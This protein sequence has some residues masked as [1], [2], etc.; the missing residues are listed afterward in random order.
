MFIFVEHKVW[1]ENDTRSHQLFKRMRDIHDPYQTFQNLN[2]NVKSSFN[3]IKIN[4][5]RIKIEFSIPSSSILSLSKLWTKKQYKNKNLILLH[6]VSLYPIL[7]SDT[8]PI[9]IFKDEDT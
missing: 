5:I 2:I 6:Y 7:N 9:V 3:F 1:I 8:K 4:S